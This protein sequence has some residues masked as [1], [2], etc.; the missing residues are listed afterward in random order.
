[1]VARIGLI[2]R[3][4][5]SRLCWCTPLVLI[6]CAGILTTNLEPASQAHPS[7][8]SPVKLRTGSPFSRVEYRSDLR[9]GD[10]HPAMRSIEYKHGEPRASSGESP[11]SGRIWR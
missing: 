6:T 7:F 3:A 10:Y 2:A 5:I 1:M 8:F 11:A 4:G 9:P